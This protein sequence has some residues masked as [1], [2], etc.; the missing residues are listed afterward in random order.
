VRLIPERENKWPYL[1]SEGYK[2]TSI[3]TWDYNCIA[4]AADV[5]DEWWWPDP[6][7]DAMWPIGKRE[8]TKECFIEAFQF[9][10]Y[11]DHETCNGSLESGIE[12]IAIYLLNGIPTHAAKQLPDGR[13]K[14]KLGPWQD[15]EHNTTKAVEEY[16]Y[17]KAVIFMKRK[18]RQ[19]RI[20][21]SNFTPLSL[22][23]PRD[24]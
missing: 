11:S 18:S 2:V 15:I 23:A 14:S 7:G 8:V 1:F 24:F 9:V 21:L 5:E 3:E 6:D 16:V 17:G 20:A 13:W 19:L 10:G 4:F 12:K 22:P